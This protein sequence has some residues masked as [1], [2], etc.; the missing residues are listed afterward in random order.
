MPAHALYFT[1]YEKTKSYNV[2]KG[3]LTGNTAGHSNT[4]AYGAAG[5]V[6]TLIHDA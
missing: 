2:F 5:A 1:V 6:A 3:F 4:L